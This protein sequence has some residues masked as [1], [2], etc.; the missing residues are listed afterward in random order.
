MFAAKAFG[1]SNLFVHVEDEKRGVAEMIQAALPSGG[2][3]LSW[4]EWR[5]AFTHQLSRSGHE[6]VLVLLQGPRDALNRV[7]N[8]ISS[9]N[10]HAARIDIMSF[11]TSELSGR[12][13]D[14]KRQK[15]M[16]SMSMKPIASLSHQSVGGVIDHAWTLESNIEDLL[17]CRDKLSQACKVQASLQDY[18]SHTQDGKVVQSPNREEIEV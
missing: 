5:E 6:L 8:W 9:L 14:R 4:G 15:V 10:G 16:Q 13:Q 17:L 11:P 12:R 7:I 2:R 18:L 3:Y 1:Y